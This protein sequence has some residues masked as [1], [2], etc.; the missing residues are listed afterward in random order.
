MRGFTSANID[1][2]PRGVAGKLKLGLG[3]FGGDR[4]YSVPSAYRRRSMQTAHIRPYTPT[5]QALLTATVRNRGHVSLL[6]IFGKL[7]RRLV[8]LFYFRFPGSERVRSNSSPVIPPQPPPPPPRQQH[9]ICHGPT[10]TFRRSQLGKNTV[11]VK[12]FFYQQLYRH[13]VNI[14]SL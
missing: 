2:P 5:D 8:S 11:S 14:V 12:H 1:C 3:N 13:N 9:L 7:S 6:A 4:K 10:Y